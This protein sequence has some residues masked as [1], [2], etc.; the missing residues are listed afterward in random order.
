MA[1][2][3]AQPAHKTHTRRGADTARD[4]CRMNF[5]SKATAICYC[6]SR[7]APQHVI[8]QYDR[9]QSIYNRSQ[10]PPPNHTHTHKWIH[11]ASIPYIQ[12]VQIQ[13]TLYRYVCTWPP[14]KQPALGAPG[15]PDCKAAW[16]DLSQLDRMISLTGLCRAASH[17]LLPVAASIMDAATAPRCSVHLAR[18]AGGATES[19]QPPAAASCCFHLGCSYSTPTST[20]AL[21][22]ARRRS[23]QRFPLPLLPDVDEC[24]S[25]GVKSSWRHRVA[26]AAACHAAMAPP[27]PHLVSASHA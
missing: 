20:S 15:F 25:I 23:L 2:S 13:G 7:C 16:P 11:P 18:A 14:W 4:A 21:L 5:N 19:C 10:S 3:F 26:A 27:A 1:C 8:Y 24:T 12:R 6:S 17:L 22:A 9:S